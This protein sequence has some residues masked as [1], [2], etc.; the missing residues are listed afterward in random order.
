M[1]NMDPSMRTTG[2]LALALFL[3]LV[4]GGYSIGKGFSKFRMADRY[5][6][7]K[8]LAE[9][10]VQA[11]LAVWPIRFSATGNDL[12][13]V[14]GEIERNKA[15]VTGFLIDNGLS[16]ADFSV[17]RINVTDLL[18][19]AYRQEGAMQSRFIIN[20][21]VDARTDKVDTV[22]KI[23]G[24]TGD[25][26][27]KGVVLSE[28]QGPT[29]IF[30]KLNDVKPAMIAEATA[31]ARQAAAQ[32][33]ADSKSRLGKIKRANQ[34]VFM[35]LARDGDQVA[36]EHQQIDKKVRVVSTVDYYIVN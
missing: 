31:N 18:A 35:I 2:A 30:T 15:L 28:F 32:F 16:E 29:Y 27:R 20:A 10:D 6:T 26:V 23:S 1:I 5:V 9:K 4:I 34:G 17:G 22:A 3:G 21:S 36:M 19:Q 33:A 11:D 7:V 25:L 24:R 12:A 14:Q 8:G 13:E